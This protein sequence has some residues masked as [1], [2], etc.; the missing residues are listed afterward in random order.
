MAEQLLTLN[1]NSLRLLKQNDEE[2]QMLSDCDALIEKLQK[3]N[4]ALKEQKKLARKYLHRIPYSHL[5]LQYINT[6]LFEKNLPGNS[7]GEK[8]LQE[9]FAYDYRN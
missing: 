6:Q 8:G 7:Q 1:E 9:S 3:E 5:N 2:K 4:A